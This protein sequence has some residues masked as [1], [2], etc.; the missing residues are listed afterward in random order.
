MAKKQAINIKKRCALC[1]GLGLVI[2]AVIGWLLSNINTEHA[3]FKGEYSF[4]EA[5]VQALD[6]EWEF[7]WN[8]LLTP[9]AFE[10]MDE[11]DIAYV[12][13]PQM[14]N[15]YESVEF[16]SK[17]TV[18]MGYGTFRLKISNLEPGKTYGLKLKNVGTSGKV[19]IDGEQVIEMGR[20]ATVK[21][22]AITDYRVRYISYIPTTQQMELVVQVSNHNYARGG[23]WAP[24]YIGTYD[25]IAMLKEY[26]TAKTYSSLGILLS[27]FI[28][29]LVIILYSIEK[30]AG[31]YLVIGT[32][33]VV[34][35]AVATGD[36]IILNW[37]PTLND[38]IVRIQ[39][40]AMYV[41]PYAMVG[42][43]KEYYNIK[44]RLFNIFFRG[45]V[46]YSGVML[47]MVLTSP[48][49]LL[50]QTGRFGNVMTIIVMSILIFF[51]FTR[52]EYNSSHGVLVGAGFFIFAFG[53][54]HDF[55]MSA[56]F[57]HAIYGE[58]TVV[59]YV[60]FMVILTFLM[61]NK[62]KKT[63][64]KSLEYNALE[65][66]YYNMQ[67][68]PHFIFNVL[69]SI[70]TLMHKDTDMAE[71][72]V[73]NLSSHLRN[74]IDPSQRRSM[75]SIQEELELLRTYIAIEQIRFA[76][77]DI[78][79]EQLY[80]SPLYLPPYTLQPLV[81]N[82]I[83]HGF[84]KKHHDKKIEVRIIEE[85]TSFRLEVQDNGVGMSEECIEWLKSLEH[86]EKHHLGLWNVNQ[87]LRRLCN[88]RLQI[89]RQKSQ[90]TCIFFI[91]NK[92]EV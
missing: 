53:T 81:E 5:R 65:A 4:S 51:L 71:E 92:S 35:F 45:T 43:F 31:I 58:L 16:S 24:F 44:D 46:L 40:G 87:R 36:K 89:E 62:I 69:N 70:L 56:T 38:E 1:I 39:Y 80:Q 13:V 34:L 33:M 21:S 85:K 63:H 49:Y 88:T 79:I 6:G 7:V 10:K 22:E 74:T 84:R 90:G 11:Q 54:I 20:V 72:M 55:F 59:S 67:I 82:A 3:A 9:E 14:W 32:W 42:F 15:H 76:D 12:Q 86:V 26:N 2:I 47:T 28:I 77:I 25:N 30:R 60:V 68:K 75:I 61:A 83:K 8:Q 41:A 19:F 66:A 52:V 48:L 23:F 64:E 27:I 18:G 91:I 78:G 37:V 50:T 73:M 17:K 29:G 57:I